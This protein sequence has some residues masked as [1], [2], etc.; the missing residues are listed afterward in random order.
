MKQII[1]F[2]IIIIFFSLSSHGQLS[3][4]SG[5]TPFIIDFED[6][7]DGVNIGEYLGEGFTTSPG[8]GQVNSNAWAT[9]GMSDGDSDFGDTNESGDFARGHIE[10]DVEEGG[11]YSFDVYKQ[12]SN[13]DH[14]FGFQPT[15]ED[16]TPGT[17]TLR[18][19]N[20]TGEYI[21]GVDIAYEVWTNNDGNFSTSCN[22]SYSLDNS[23]FTGI[24]ALDFESR[25][26]S[27]E[28]IILAKPKWE[29][30]NKSLTIRDIAIPA[31]SSLYLRWE[32]DD[33]Y[34]EPGDKRD[35]FALDD[36][37]VEVTTATNPAPIF[38]SISFYKYPTTSET[39][40][41]T[42]NITDANGTVKSDGVTLKYGTTSGS[43]P[44][45]ISM[46]NSSGDEYTATIPAQASEGSIFFIIE[47]EDNESAT[48]TSVEQSFIVR[49]PVL[50]EIPYEEP[51]TTNLGDCY[52]F[53][54]LGDSKEWYWYEEGNGSNY[55]NFAN[56]SGFNSEEAEEDWLM[57]PGVDLSVVGI[58]GNFVLTFTSWYNYGSDDVGS[59]NLLYSSNYSGTGS[60]NAGGVTWDTLN[61][62]RPER[63]DFWY[64]SDN[65]SLPVDVSDTIYM[66][67]KYT[68]PNYNYRTWRIDDIKIIN[69]FIADPPPT[70]YPTSFLATEL[71]GS[72]IKVTWVD[73]TAD[74]LAGE[75][76]PWGYQIHAKTT[77][78]NFVPPVD[79]FPR[80][81]DSDLR[82]GYGV[83]NIFHGGFESVT[84]TGLYASTQY[85]FIVYP[86]SNSGENIKYKKDDSPPTSS[87]TTTAGSDASPGEV[88]ITEF[89]S[90]PNDVSD[91]D[92]EW[93]EIFNTTD[94]PINIDGWVIESSGSGV[95][96]HTILGET[97]LT[98]APKEFFVLGLN[99][100]SLTNGGVPVDYEYS[101]IFLSNT[102]DT[103]RI[104]TDADVV[105]DFIEWG[106]GAVWENQTARSL[107]FIGVPGEDNNNGNKWIPALIR[108]NGYEDP[109]QTPA[110]IIEHDLGSPGTNG[111]YQNLVDTTT[112]I[113]SGEWSYG[114]RVGQ[115]NWTNGAPGLE[116]QVTVKGD[117]NVD[118][119]TKFP[120]QCGKLIIDPTTG[121][122]VIPPNKALTT[123]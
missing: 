73:A 42:A 70:N 55:R 45:P 21:V 31:S 49:N 48:G 88:I 106:D 47:A 18:V 17:I 36:I 14:A 22:F 19:V 96:R 20:N 94:A 54:A 119:P 99:A 108:E 57:L 50:T 117:V 90:D 74:T 37:T 92:G 83:R 103:L 51:F 59:F 53:N 93:F 85:D 2:S 62:S 89:M 68:N 112:W 109:E 122:V 80:P 121:N 56:V 35:E 15:E 120:A 13:T 9:T 65:V 61:F 46:T 98:I 79:S 82:D 78:Q 23:S 8:N 12:G 64:Y 40:K 81:D 44:N 95:E 66:A 77:D 102:F 107:Y 118:L 116:V 1:L 26:V 110:N 72:A 3:I 75:T 69:D 4:T 113:G 28:D 100:D 87:A 105:M 123:K 76:L 27:T 10:G 104:L 7:V 71:N 63:Y 16:F 11:F 97:G 91:S 86:Y 24:S 60:P 114:N 67:F 111:L 84:W 32:T 115:T 29:V 43:Y 38:N 5:G 6:D 39:V 58:G 41:V 25:Q 30:E 34:G 33:I 101:D 52:V